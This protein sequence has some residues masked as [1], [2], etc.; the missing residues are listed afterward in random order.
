MYVQ[1]LNAVDATHSTSIHDRPT[2]VRLQ[3]DSLFILGS[4][5]SA[6]ERGQA[7]R[8]ARQGEKP[9]RRSCP[10]RPVVTE[11][12]D[13]FHRNPESALLFLPTPLT[14]VSQLRGVAVVELKGWLHNSFR[15]TQTIEQMG[16]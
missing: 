3:N 15:Q 8:Q 7:V 1:A 2:G 4:P 14:H 6:A 5:T 12:Y 11:N 10:A 16:T 9:C 13:W